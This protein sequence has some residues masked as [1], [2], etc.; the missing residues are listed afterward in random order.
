MKA[1]DIAISAEALRNELNGIGDI[2]YS[3]YKAEL[4]EYR[5]MFN[6][7]LVLVRELAKLASPYASSVTTMIP[8]VLLQPKGE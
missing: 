5:R 4:A 8:T 6:D 3:N 7:M 2:G 1:E